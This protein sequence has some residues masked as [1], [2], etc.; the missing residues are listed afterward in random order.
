MHRRRLLTGLALALGL[1][2]AVGLVAWTG[3]G[4]V[5][6]GLAAVGWGLLGV[7][8]LHLLVMQVNALSLRPLLAQERG[9]RLGALALLRV[10]WIGDAVNALLPVGQVGGE[11]V[12]ARLLA[13][14]GV[15]GAEAGAA[16][17]A[18]LTA[19]IV[20]QILFAAAGLLAL[21]LLAGPGGTELLA[22]LGLGLA[23]L[24][25]AV[26]G[27][28]HGQRHGLFLGLARR[29]ERLSGGRRWL[30][31]TGGAA[32]LDR[33]LQALYG[34]R[35]AFLACCAWR[36]AGWLLG[37]LQVW[38]LLWLLGGRGGWLDAFALES[39]GQ[40]AKSAGF[41]VPGALGLQEGGFAAAAL[42]LGLSSHL[43]VTI[44]LV[45]RVRDLLLGLPGL[46]AWQWIEGR[47]LLSGRA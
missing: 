38:L 9:P 23:V 29:L 31:L 5:L 41:A 32:A 27:F 15:P 28:W 24:A 10:W 35:R 16:V 47:G 39:L 12:R 40:A 25:A 3:F 36:L 1:A 30:D 22:W 4:S 11:L 44:S 43:G 45:K 21:A 42:A 2:L 37:V 34:R 8:A 6:E 13:R 20:T 7:L 33:A 46:L 14:A 17:I 19:G 18:T 26:W